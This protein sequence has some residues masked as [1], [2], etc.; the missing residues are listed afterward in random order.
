[1]KQTLDQL[2]DIVLPTAQDWMRAVQLLKQYH[3]GNTALIEA[4]MGMCLQYL[5]RTD[6]TLDHVFISAGE[7]AMA[8]LTECGMLKDNVL[9]WDALEARKLKPITWEQAVNKYVADEETRKRLIALGG[10]S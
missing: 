4:L 1:M 7:H 8:I 10:E 6:G 9:D 2:D 3:N 5:E